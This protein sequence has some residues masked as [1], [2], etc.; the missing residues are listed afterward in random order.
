MMRRTCLAIRTAAMIAAMLVALTEGVV[1]AS[2]IKANAPNNIATRAEVTAG[3]YDEA[4]TFHQSSDERFGTSDPDVS[5]VFELT[6]AASHLPATGHAKDIAEGSASVGITWGAPV[7][8]AA[9]DEIRFNVSGMISAMEARDASGNPLT[10]FVEVSARAMF[11]LDAGYAG[12]APN[13]VVGSLMLP[14]LRA[15]ESFEHTLML[16][17]F[18]TPTDPMLSADVIALAG[19]DAGF[20]IDL[21]ADHSYALVLSYAAEVPFGVDPPLD[22][23][24]AVTIVPEPHSAAMA[25]AGLML[26]LRRRRGRD[27]RRVIRRYILLE[28]TGVC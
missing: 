2:V 15:M 9:Y 25:C 26:L 19:G 10:G 23:N 13:S 5:P 1:D 11:Y 7:G 18:V 21:R 22:L 14:S 28:S 27:A 17:V 16:E 12:A 8:P 6:V 20:R 3:Y 4:L 24:V